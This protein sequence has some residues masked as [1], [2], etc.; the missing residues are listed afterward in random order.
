MNYCRKC[1][2]DYTTSGTCNCF[3]P[4]PAASP[5]VVPTV[6]PW[7]P[8]PLPYIG[9]PLPQYRPYWRVDTRPFIAPGV[10][11]GNADAGYGSSYRLQ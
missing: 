5:A 7:T 1:Q 3:A 8:P 2:S 9:D 6:V 11:Y 4:I 10:W